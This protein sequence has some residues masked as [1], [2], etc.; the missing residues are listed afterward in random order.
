MW[1]RTPGNVIKRLQAIIDNPG[2]L[3]RFDELTRQVVEGK[4]WQQRKSSQGR[5]FDCFTA[6]LTAPQPHGLGV[7]STEKLRP[8]LCWLKREQHYATLAEVIQAVRRRRGARKNPDIAQGDICPRF[9][10][11]DRSSSSLDQLLPR[12]QQHPEWFARV[13]SGELTPH[14]AALLLG[15]LTRERAY[16]PNPDGL[17]RFDVL[18][19]Y[20]LKRLA[21]KPKLRLACEFFR[22]LDEDTC[23]GLITECI[24]PRLGPGLA[25]LWRNQN[26]G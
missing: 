2:G 7:D 20:A 22:A 13:C 21:A 1:Q 19:L 11:P 4:Y 24:E 17:R 18:N 16:W 15:L 12:L 25:Q 6:F 5:A 26:V 10:T 23:C 14:K 9:Y 3:S 8:F